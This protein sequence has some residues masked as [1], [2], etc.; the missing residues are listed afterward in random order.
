MASTKDKSTRSGPPKRASTGEPRIRSSHGAP[1]TSRAR[2]VKSGV[3]ANDDETPHLAPRRALGAKVPAGAK[4]AAGPKTKKALRPP[5]SSHASGAGAAESSSVASDEARQTAIAIAAAALDKKAVGL[6]ILDVAGKVDYADFLVLMTGRSDRQVIALSQG[7]EE[8]L[9]KKNRRPLSVEGLPHANWVLMDF[10]D[11]V[12]HIFQDETR[13]LY[14][15]EGL[16]LDAR[17]LSVP[18]PEDLR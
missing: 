6:E 14:D 4:A 13:G 1:P 2:T 3:K 12:V 16:W 5:K 7:I 15:L 10:G 11:I 8:A 18:I 17:R 9:R